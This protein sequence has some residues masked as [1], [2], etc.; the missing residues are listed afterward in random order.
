ML[1]TKT[2][3]HTIRVLLV[4]DHEVIR[5]G[6]RTVLAQS[7]GINVVGEAG[8]VA[9][10][11]QQSQKLK[12]DVILMD[13]RLPDGSGVDACREILGA[14]PSTRIVFL[15]SYADDDSVLAAVLA[16]AHGYVLKEIDSLGLL[17]AI[18]SVANGQSILDSTVTERALRWLRGLHDLPATPGTDQ[19]SSQEERVVALVAE[20]K[21]NKEIAVALGLSDKTVKNYLANVFQKLRITRRTQAAAFFVKRQG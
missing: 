14:L 8:T 7:Q 18:R 6:L 4:D 11:V 16:G 3:V 15:T 19:L 12:P 9:D 5:V 10:A 1:T 20:G 21:T 2:P 17:E 13:V